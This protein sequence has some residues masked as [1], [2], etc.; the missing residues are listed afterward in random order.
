MPDG[1]AAIAAEEK[2]SHCSPL[3]TEL[4]TYGGIPAIGRLDFARR[5]M[6]IAI[7]EHERN[8]IFNDGGGLDIAFLGWRQAVYQ[9]QFKR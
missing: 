4:G 9:G 8:S 7:I 1:V 5:G 6:Q 3:T 2:V